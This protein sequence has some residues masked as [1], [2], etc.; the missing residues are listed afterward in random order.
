MEVKQITDALHTTPASGSPGPVT[1]CSSEY[2]TVSPFNC[3]N[4]LVIVEYRDYMTL[5][6]AI[7]GNY[8]KALP[9][10][11]GPSSC[12][13]W[14]VKVSGLLYFFQG[15]SVMVYDVLTGS[16]KQIANFSQYTRIYNGGESDINENNLLVIAGEIPSKLTTE[17]FLFNVK[18]GVR[19]AVL[20]VVPQWNALYATPDGGV[21]IC[22]EKA[23]G[24]GIEYWTPGSNIVR[25]VA[26]I[27]SHQDVCRDLDGSEIM[28]WANSPDPS[29][30]N[31]G[32]EKIRLADGKRTLLYAFGWDKA[33]IAASL[34]CHISAPKN[35][36][37]Y[38][39]VETYD[40]TNPNSTK[41]FANAILRVSLDP[42]IMPVEITKHKSDTFTEIGQPKA[43]SSRDGSKILFSS[44]LGIRTP[45]IYS[46]A[47]LLTTDP[48]A[49]IKKNPVD[50]P[51]TTGEKLVPMDFHK[52][53]EGTT[54]VIRLTVVNGQLVATMFNVEK[55]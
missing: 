10:Q 15:N 28:V 49:P 14:D 51:T 27:L 9:F 52:S 8:L 55:S 2:P 21:L 47:F 17:I 30:N 25:R 19:S 40:V 31:N 32:I 33:N 41:P 26:P 4:N 18:T 1:C 37:G 38:V 36:P 35:S 22:W 42:A 12:P 29:V 48:V 7:S 16:I 54:W 44:N 45:A 3:D 39:Y 34:A 13:R 24:K 53:P 20:T 5:H 6:G 46:E 23:T 50:P 43:S 11:I